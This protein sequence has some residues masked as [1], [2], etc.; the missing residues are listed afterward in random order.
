MIYKYVYN[1]SPSPF[2][3]LGIG[4]NLLSDYVQSTLVMLT[5]CFQVL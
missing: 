2:V 4:G 1:F 5:L 3:N